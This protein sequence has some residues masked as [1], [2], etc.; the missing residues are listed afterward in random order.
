M[1]VVA[2]SG[3]SILGTLVQSAVTSVRQRTVA[4]VVLRSVQAR[5]LAAA[6]MRRPVSR[7]SRLDRGCLGHWCRGWGKWHCHGLALLVAL[8]LHHQIG[9]RHLDKVV[10]SSSKDCS[11]SLVQVGLHPAGWVRW[12][13]RWL[14][15][16]AS[17]Q[18]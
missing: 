13:D 9:L 15:W 7:H 11:S 2:V 16:S 12:V 4:L 14:M 8:W 10:R 3:V 17:A 18:P 5:A 1:P 6:G